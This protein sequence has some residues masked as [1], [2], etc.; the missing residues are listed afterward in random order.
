MITPKNGKNRAKGFT[1][2]EVLIAVA[3]SAVLMAGLWALFDTYE[4]LFS[5]GQV[6][7]ENAQLVRALLEQIS[8]DLQNAIPDSSAG[9]PG[10]SAS[11][12]RFGLFG[13]Q[14]ALQVDVLR[15]TDSQLA[16]DSTGAEEPADPSRPER[17]PELHTVQYLFEE[18]GESG[19]PRS[20]DVTG[21]VRR[22]LD[23]ETP[24]GGRQRS[25]ASGQRAGK[26]FLR[27]GSS[28]AAASLDP[29]DISAA[30]LDPA[31]N[32][33]LLVPEVVGLEFRYYDGSGW[34]SQWNSLTRKSLP[35]A[36]EVTLTL[37][38]SPEARRP[39]PVAAAS[40]Q[41]GSAES[42]TEE[43]VQV[44]TRTHRLLVF[45]PGTMLAV[46]SR[47]RPTVLALP[48]APAGPVYQPPPVPRAPAAPSAR[49]GS[50]AAGSLRAVLPDQWMR[51]GP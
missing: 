17:V 15:V 27:K 1:L 49:S 16:S 50:R 21:L 26:T 13:T 34:N 51:A 24:A 2:L 36:V 29:M 47:E 9:L 22:E 3:L 46:S 45:L 23:W 43:P 31:D 8:D 19:G 6:K 18:A 20:G 39:R 30:N 5:R 38:T 35:V 10:Q 7:V 28:F 25:G 42:L 44:E 32:S 33:L 14:S 37:K 4:K 41:G 11:V 40:E 12:R 48:A